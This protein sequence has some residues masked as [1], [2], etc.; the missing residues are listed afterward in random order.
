MLRLFSEGFSKTN[1]IWQNIFFINPW[2]LPID[3]DKR[4]KKASLFKSM[5]PAVNLSLSL[6]FPRRDKR[7]PRFKISLWTG[8]LETKTFSNASRPNGCVLLGLN[9]GIF[10]LFYGAKFKCSFFDISVGRFF[11]PCQTFSNAPLSKG[12]SNP[13][14][15]GWERSKRVAHKGC[16]ISFLSPHSFMIRSYL[17]AR[18]QLPFGVGFWKKTCNRVKRGTARRVNN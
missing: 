14:G 6:L 16:E 9:R 15:V 4:S 13:A 11:V 8:C 1:T 17:N 18:G 12:V 5:F 2:N 7:N 10:V 3:K